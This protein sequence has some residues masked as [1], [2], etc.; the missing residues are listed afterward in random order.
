MN[1]DKNNENKKRFI[2]RITSEKRKRIFLEK[3]AEL[4]LHYFRKSTTKLFFEQCVKFKFQI[5]LHVCYKL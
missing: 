4:P 2:S 1:Y 3:L 5:V